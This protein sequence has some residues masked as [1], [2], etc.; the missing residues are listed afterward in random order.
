MR[1]DIKKKRTLAVMRLREGMFPGMKITETK[2]G[3]ET[4]DMEI[5]SMR[6]W[7]GRGV[8]MLTLLVLKLL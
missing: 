5:T 2:M 1:L 6:L 3:E 7:E 4:G 8:E